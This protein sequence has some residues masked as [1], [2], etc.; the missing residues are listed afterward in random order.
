[1]AR[2]LLSEL[3]LGGEILNVF[4]LSMKGISPPLLPMQKE[5]SEHFYIF[6]QKAQHIY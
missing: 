2:K 5:S 3:V 6:L 1:M 4:V